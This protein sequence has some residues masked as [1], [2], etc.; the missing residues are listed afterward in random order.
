MLTRAARRLVAHDARHGEKPFLIAV[1]LHKPHIRF[2]A[3]DA[4]FDLYP[5]ASLRLVNPPKNDWRERF[6]ET[7]SEGPA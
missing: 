3:P 2:L 6:S 7:S 1:S 5:K 4:Y